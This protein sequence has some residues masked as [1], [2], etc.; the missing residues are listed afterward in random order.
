[1]LLIVYTLTIDLSNPYSRTLNLFT[2][3]MSKLYNK[4]KWRMSLLDE[5]ADSTKKENFDHENRHN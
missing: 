4:P 3:H 5:C 1:M 2:I